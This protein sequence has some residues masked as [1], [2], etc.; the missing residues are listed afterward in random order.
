MS[1]D[2]NLNSLCQLLL[3]NEKEAADRIYLRQ[4]KKGIWHE[5]T[6]AE[7]MLQARKVAA[8]LYQ[9]GLKK[10]D[11]VAIISKN[12][13]EWFIADF[14]IYLAGMVSVPLF[15]NQH[16][17]SVHYILE[18]GDVN[19]VFIGKLDEHQLVRSYIPEQH[20]T[21]SFGY[22]KDLKVNH[23][24]S[25]VLATQPL[26]ELTEPSPEDVYTIIYSSGTSG[27]PK[28]AMFTN[29]SIT[30]YLN[31]FPEDLLRIRKLEH[32]K[33]ISYL[34]LAHVYERS[35]IQLASVTIHCDV[36]FIESLAQFSKN[37]RSIQPIFFT[38]VPRIWG[39]FQQKIEE[40]LSPSLLNFLL[41]IPFISRYIKNKIIKELGL[42]ACT[43]SFSGASP[44]PVSIIKFFEKI[45]IRIQEGYGQTENLAYATLSILNERR[46]GYVGTPRLEVEIKTAED[47]ELLLNSPCLM[48]GYYKDKE[49]TKKAFTSEGWLRTGDVVELD[50]QNRVKIVGRIS[51]NFKNQSGEFVAPTP[52]E[53]Q[54][55]INEII[56][57]LCLVGRGLPSNVLLI[58]LSEGALIRKKKEE[59]NKLLEDILH[60][61]N[62][63][64]LK[65]ER[66]SH[67]IIAKEEW[68]PKNDLLTPT[69]KV[70]RR[71]VEQHYAG[72]IESALAQSQRIIWE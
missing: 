34:P 17:K 46:P 37:L 36:S 24:W 9:L 70:K 3:K 48:S 66:I 39:I 10:G 26:I 18:H 57:Q 56:E 61:V 50:D 38:A 32:Y 20:M 45:G 23:L 7:T 2:S 63:G 14:G 41:K 52:I 49:A 33:L 22:H 30:N 11:H 71:V 59:I 28:G 12:C 47:G 19:A 67:I 60:H 4:P 1:K 69:L 54:F 16:E 65:Y 62:S 44:L 29:Q 40:K 15:T 21:I 27:L 53:Q 51:E 31:L 8:F 6:W 55:E 35:A 25:D 68:T 42:N 64:L 5:L 43:N 72:V 58:T 13:A